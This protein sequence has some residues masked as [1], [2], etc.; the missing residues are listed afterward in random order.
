MLSM[1]KRVNWYQESKKL[2]C[3]KVNYVVIGNDHLSL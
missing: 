2:M 3:K 1:S